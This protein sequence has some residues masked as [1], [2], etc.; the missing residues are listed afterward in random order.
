MDR[1][2]LVSSYISPVSERSRTPSLR[3]DPV[4]TVRSEA[5]HLSDASLVIPLSSTVGCGNKRA[6]RSTFSAI[7]TT[8]NHPKS[9]TQRMA[10]HSLMFGFRLH[11]A[12]QL[13]GVGESK[14]KHW[15]SQLLVV[16]DI[17]SFG[18]RVDITFSNKQHFYGGLW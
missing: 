17:F 2:P 5:F 6:T 13:G 9:V 10:I 18:L 14:P 11:E 4:E 3:N 1:Q 8:L 12:P 7:A 15:A 16:L